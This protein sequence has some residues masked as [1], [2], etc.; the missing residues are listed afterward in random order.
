MLPPDDDAFYWG[1]MKL[2]L[3]QSQELTKRARYR[4]PSS[5][6][7][8]TPSLPRSKSASP[9]AE[10]LAAEEEPEDSGVAVADASA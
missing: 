8:S 6:F 7:G 1:H 9:S 5:R 3:K 2:L 10:L 4:E